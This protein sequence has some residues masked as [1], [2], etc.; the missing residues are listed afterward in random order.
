MDLSNSPGR[1]LQESERLAALA[2]LNI[3]D[4][5]PEREFDELTRLA[6][7]ALGVAS[8][9]VSLIDDERQWF[10]AR[11]NIPVAETPRELS[12]CT[13]A[14]ECREA[15]VVRDARA[16][17]RFRDNPFVQGPPFIRFYAGAPLITDAGHCLGTFC[18]FDQRTRRFSPEQLAMLADLARLATD[19]IESRSER[20]MGA[21]A[22]KVI[23]ATSDAVL[24]ADQD[25]VIVYWN[26]AAEQM[27]G[28]SHAEAV[29]Q[30]VEIIM[31]ARFAQGH[32]GRFARA[33]AGGPT[34]LVGTFVELTAAR[35]DGSEFPVELS[36]ARW[37]DSGPEQGF[38]AIVR[39]IS[40]RKELER[41]REHAKAFLATIVTN[42]PAMLFVKD[43]ETRRYL[44]VNR[45]GEQVI[46]RRA[47]ELIGR[48][49]REIFPDIGRRYE[50][51]D[52]A[53][54]AA[55]GPQTYEGIHL[56]PDGRHTHLR[57][58]RIIVDGPDRAGQYLLGVSED[59]TQMRQAEAHVLELAHFDKLTGLLNRTSYTDRLHR[60][61]QHR[62]P[63]AM[64]S[65]DLDRFKAV[66]DQFGHPVG[67]AVLTE[68]GER[69]R[70]LAEPSD[71]IARIGGDEF[72]VVLLGD[73][74]RTRAQQVS[75][76]IIARLRDPFVT[77]RAVAHVGA[78]VGVVLSPEDGETTAQLRENADLA[79]Y[80][81]KRSGRGDACFFNTEMDAAAR[82]RRKL[83]GEL[84][85]AIDA[86]EIGLQYQPVLAVAT[87]QMT[88]VEALARWRHADRGPISP[89]IFIPLAEE[90]GLIDALGEHLL[91]T[92]CT[93]ALAW[94]DNVR[95]A[96]NLSPLQFLSGR[97][98]DTV[99]ATLES[100]GLA[101]NRLQLEVTEGLVIRDVDRTFAQLEQLRALGIQI[102]I[103]DFGV[104]YSSL[105]YFQRFPFDKVKI[106][107]SFVTD[108]ASS[109]SAR[110]IV[111]AVVG[112]G[113]TLGMAI[114]A[115]GVETEEQMRVLAEA[116]CTHV[117]GYLFSRPLAA[118]AVAEFA[119]STPARP[120]PARRANKLRQSSP[121][122]AAA[123]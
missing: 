79:L 12:F 41:E 76:A 46:G 58:T 60:L 77:E 111:Q 86:G 32:P 117:Q 26:P 19:L 123:G 112:L 96:V 5:P 6:A 73:E 93:D 44:M 3:M 45:A 102:L 25:G 40:S 36:L 63:F 48:T 84:R 8:A 53:A 61:V 122:A 101:A 15:L 11:H 83:E 118:E 21:I 22:A 37:G 64:L 55:T 1:F 50:Q 47:E 14:V 2:G 69:L 42:L 110:A 98:I 30:R 104:G 100:S 10:K 120:G 71:W 70:A 87:G 99:R 72:M 56:R 94:S 103:D 68:V 114:V 57:T 89:D 59:V 20:R 33:A 109:R 74:L 13:H 82:D 16:D 34:R 51:R 43:T 4:S 7:V 107:K 17:S 29:G 39:D 67:D 91:R 35:A 65:V 88:S 31:P 106:D 23:E 66:N 85:R 113:E 90:S 9:A 54:I 92:A 18:V 95:V 49:D 119:L 80:R 27:F 38:A 75:E 52:T 121:P 78:S 105:S 115:E 116:G 108:V 62:A 97:L 24:A 28:R 81:A